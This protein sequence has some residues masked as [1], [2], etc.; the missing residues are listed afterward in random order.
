MTFGYQQ[1]IMSAYFDDVIHKW[2]SNF[3]AVDKDKDTNFDSKHTFV[4]SYSYLH[5]CEDAHI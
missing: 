1:Q 4:N 2:L 3:A 5:L